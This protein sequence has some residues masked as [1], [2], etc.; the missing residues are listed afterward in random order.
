MGAISAV[1]PQRLAARWWSDRA[2]AERVALAGLAGILGAGALLR[3]LMMVAWSPGFM[4]WPDAKSY[5][6]VAHGQ[7]FSN[8]LRPAGYPMFV[9]VLD[10]LHPSLGL[11][12]VANH[13]LGL[14][15]AALLFAAVTRAGAPPL[16]ALVPAAIVALSG[17]V[18]FL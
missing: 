10:S 7:L 6:D 9:R 4:G 17:D 2:R 3:G 15:P 18:V 11:I 13:A 1:A 12:V 14:G 8:V 16:L 5:L